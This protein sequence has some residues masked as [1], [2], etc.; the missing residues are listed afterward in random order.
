MLLLDFGGSNAAIARN[1]C[2]SNAIPPTRCIH[3]AETVD[4]RNAVGEISSRSTTTRCSNRFG[5]GMVRC[6]RIIS[7]VLSIIAP[8]ST[9]LGQTASQ[10]R[11][12]KQ[13]SIWLAMPSVSGNLPSSN[14]RIKWMRPR[15]ESFSFP[16][17]KNVGQACKHS[18]QWMQASDFSRSRNGGIGVGF[19]AGNLPSEADK[20]FPAR[21]LFPA[22]AGAHFSIKHRQCGAIQRPSNC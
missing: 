21:R 20:L 4:N 2:G 11:Q 22:R 1:R 7:R 8:Y 9:P 14:P 6:W 16:V 10:A 12:P 17:S 15:G 18:P 19:M 3:R 5:N 13:R